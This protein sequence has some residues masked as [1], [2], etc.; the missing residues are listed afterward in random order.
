MSFSCFAYIVCSAG[1]KRRPANIS[2]TSEGLSASRLCSL[3]LAS[4][5][6][7]LFVSAHG[8]L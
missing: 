5:P 8:R 3:L 1:M 6:L 7:N 4:L 2:R